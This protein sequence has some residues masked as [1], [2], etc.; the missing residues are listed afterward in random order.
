MSGEYLFLFHS[1]ISFG[2]P[3]LFCWHQLR[4]LRRDGGGR[5]KLPDPVPAPPSGTDGILPPRTLPAGLV[6]QPSPFLP[7]PGQ[8]AAPARVLEDA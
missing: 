6:P 4:C 1:L 7:A 8:V 2:L 3:L 5:Q